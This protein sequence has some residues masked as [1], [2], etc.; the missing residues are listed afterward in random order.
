MISFSPFLKFA[1]Q[2]A[3]SNL[4]E[5]KA[6]ATE[7]AKFA[8][9]QPDAPKWNSQIAQLGD[10]AT[11]A[12]T[13]TSA[14]EGVA[15]A[16][17]DFGASRAVMAKFWP[18]WVRPELA[19][20]LSAQPV[21]AVA[22]PPVEMEARLVV[23]S[24]KDAYKFTPAAKMAA[25]TAPQIHPAT[26]ASPAREMTPGERAEA[27]T[28]AARARIESEKAARF[29]REHGAERDSRR[30][31]LLAKYTAMP[32]GPE[33]VAFLSA[34]SNDLFSAATLVARSK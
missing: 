6:L 29:S 7:V 5:A 31:A 18:K 28:A 4:A 12:K 11:S 9:D 13:L 21:A 33:R 17:L 15:Q 20:K 8:A 19:A 14:C 32:A 2:G 26:A 22:G 10:L 34:N 25:V 1:V 16:L 3:P 27:E 30:L 24:P 23:P